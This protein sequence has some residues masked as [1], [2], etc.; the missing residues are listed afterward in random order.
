M[1]NY[2]KLF[3]GLI[4]CLSLL[5]I[6]SGCSGGGGSGPV[7]VSIQVTPTNPSIALGTSQQVNATGIYS[8]NS[9][10][11]VT[12]SVTWS[13]SSAAVATVSN[14]AGANGMATSVAAGSTTIKATMGA[15]FGTTTLTVTSAT[16]VSIGVT[17]TNPSIALGRSQQFTA[18]GVFTDNTVQ[19]LTTQVAWSSS[20]PAFAT[21]GASTGLAS[22]VAAGSTTITATMAGKSGSSVLAVTPAVLTDIDV[23]PALPS[24]ALGTPQ[25][26][27]ATGT[28]SDNTTEDLTA[29]VTWTSS[30]TAVATVNSSGLATTTGTGLATITATLGAI[31]GSTDL[32]VNA[33]TLVSIDVS[34]TDP[35]IPMGITQQFSASGNYSD[36]SVQ[37]LTALVTW[38]SSNTGIAAISNA[39]GSSGLATPVAPGQTTITATLGGKSGSSTLTVTAATLTSIA[40]TPANPRIALGTKLQFTATGT[41]S[42]ATIQDLTA[43]VAWNSSNVAIAT[44]SNAGVT[45]GLAT[46]VAAGAT[47]ITAA[48]GAVSNTVPVT[49]TV[50]NAT[51]TSI[52]VTPANTTIFLGA[53][54]QYT[55]IGN[56]NDASTQDLTAQVTWR[57]VNKTIAA[58]S[59][60]FGSNG[61]VT[62]IRAG[63][64]QVNATFAFAGVTGSTGV[65]VS[66]ATLTGI[67][68]TPA[69]PTLAVGKTLQF[70]ATGVFAGGLTQDLTNSVNTTWSSSNRAMATVINVPKKN[71]GLA[72]GVSAGTVTIKASDRRGVIFG[73]TV[74]TVTP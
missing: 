31:F 9:K 15:V 67:I 33:A 18:T 55:A 52:T 22:S 62:P 23:T 37:D 38:S 51:L 69:N 48:L 7:L 45:R 72:K 61:L 1:R 30:S 4:C 44:I 11:D 53:T 42:D 27:T 19:D 34:P 47:T 21:V 64:T 63:V 17:P 5:G 65:T 24:I 57:V 36:G 74:L 13:S 6:L 71:K 49:L 29:V 50:T 8:D 68:I 54:E 39:S 70:T 59:N 66:S 20:L 3:L 10:Q 41:Y 25:Q 12:A 60:A 28:Y 46:S 73:T 56:F 26:F 40:I 32:T 43:F 16:L 14:S 35:S 58:V 2:S